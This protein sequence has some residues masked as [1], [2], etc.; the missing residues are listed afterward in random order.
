[1]GTASNSD[2]SDIEDLLWK[3]SFAGYDVQET[4]DTDEGV[5]E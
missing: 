3:D 5:M 4:F 1:M 2:T